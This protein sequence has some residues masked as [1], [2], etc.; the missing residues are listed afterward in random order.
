MNYPK[1]A[2]QLIEMLGGKNNIKALA[3]CATRL[4]LA[5]EDESLINETAIGDLEG[6]KGQFKVAGQYQIIFGSGIVNQVYAQMAK[7]TG[8]EEM[9]TKDVA[10]AGAEKQ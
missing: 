1:T 7:Q 10:S 5:I 9:S 8:L 6:V 4:R 3:H 2:S